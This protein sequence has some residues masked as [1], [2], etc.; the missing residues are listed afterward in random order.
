[1]GEPPRPGTDYTAP[2]PLGTLTFEANE[3]RDTL[4]V[5]VIGDAIDE[6]NETVIVELSGPSN[7]TIATATGTGTIT[8]DDLEPRMGLH[9]SA[10]TLEENGSPNVTTVTATLSHPSSAITTVTVRAIPDSTID[11]RPRARAEDFT[12]SS[13]DTLLIAAGATTS[14]GTVTITANNNNRDEPTKYV[15]VSARAENSRRVGNSFNELGGRK[16]GVYN[17][18]D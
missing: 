2:R 11:D 6:P 8:N 13:A 12:L 9:L 3:T 5:A 10:S 17:P 4:K 14:T 18:A 15:R 7:A 16:R 1:M